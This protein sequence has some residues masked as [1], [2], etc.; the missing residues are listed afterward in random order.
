MEGNSKIEIPLQ[1]NPNFFVLRI[2]YKLYY[3]YFIA[4]VGSLAWRNTFEI[5]AKE[6]IGL[7]I[8]QKFMSEYDCRSRF[9]LGNI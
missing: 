8:D 3:F 7:L 2:Y 4:I 9:V 6:S 1:I 5:L